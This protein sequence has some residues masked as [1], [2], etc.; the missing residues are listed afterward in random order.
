MK[1]LSAVFQDLQNRIAA[2]IPAAHIAVNADSAAA[3]NDVRTIRTDSLPSVVISLDRIGY[4]EGNLV[5][6]ISL[7]LF[8]TDRFSADSASRASSALT[9][10]ETI[11]S[12]FPPEGGLLDGALCLPGELI[13]EAP[14]SESL[15][16]RWRFG[17]TVKQ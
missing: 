12:L 17:L 1:E 5:R 8:L 6:V 11:Q 4:E 2:V 14:D 13:P 7:T 3:A 10:C 9:L 15:C 16:C